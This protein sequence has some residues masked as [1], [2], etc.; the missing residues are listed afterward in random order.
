MITPDVFIRH[1]P[2]YTDSFLLSIKAVMIFGKVTD[3]N[4]RGGLRATGAPSKNQNPFY[5]E[6]FEALD[7]LVSSDFIESL[8]QIYKNNHG[9]NDN[10]STIDTD[11]YMV[12]IIPHAYV[13]MPHLK[14]HLLTNIIEQL[15]LSI[16]HTWIS[17]ILSAFQLLDVSTLLARSCP[18]IICF[19]QRLWTSLG[20]TLSSR[21]GLVLASFL[22]LLTNQ[23][24]QTDMLVFGRCSSSAIVQILH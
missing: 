11:L 6:G 14:P 9:V 23:K 20:F 17:L 13:Q 22:C 16:I 4:V 10:G 21:Y 8:P 12:H 5:L 18:R 7:K 3:F 19:L 2:Q 15:S 24:C 1:P